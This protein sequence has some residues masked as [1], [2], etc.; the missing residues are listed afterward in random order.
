MSVSRSTHTLFRAFNHISQSCWLIQ[1]SRSVM[2]PKSR[3]NRR[4]YAGWESNLCPCPPWCLSGCPGWWALTSFDCVVSGS[5]LDFRQTMLSVSVVACPGSLLFHWCSDG[6][7][8][9][10]LHPGSGAVQ[11]VLPEMLRCWMFCG[12][13][14]LLVIWR[15]WLDVLIVQPCKSHW[16][17]SDVHCLVCGIPSNLKL[18][19]FHHT[20]LVAVSPEWSP[21]CDTS[22]SLTPSSLTRSG[23]LCRMVLSI[24]LSCCWVLV[25]IQM[26]LLVCVSGFSVRCGIDGEVLCQNY[27]LLKKSNDIPIGLSWS[28]VQCKMANSS[29]LTC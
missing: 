6:I 19:D 11:S 8:H 21:A 29:T 4:S 15:F 7:H 28:C 9:S 22:L 5:G 2:W 18:W 26:K 17:E 13:C 23:A 16:D 3:D 14:W 27:K 24:H 12:N 25:S 10:S 1:L 20:L